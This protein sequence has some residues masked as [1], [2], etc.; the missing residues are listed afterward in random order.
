MTSTTTVY[1]VVHREF[2]ACD[3]EGCVFTSREEARRAI[4]L[5][6]DYYNRAREIYAIEELN[7]CQ[8]VQDFY[9]FHTLQYELDQRNSQIF[10]ALSKKYG[11]SIID[12]IVELSLRRECGL[13]FVI[14]YKF[15]DAIS[16]A[17]SM[18]IVKEWIKEIQTDESPFLLEQPYAEKK[19]SLKHYKIDVNLAS[20]S[21]DICL[22]IR[23]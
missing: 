19:R 21:R 13:N 5:L 9:L 15:P 11:E 22:N 23:W 17:K 18:E 8:R 7:V 6:C 14:D 16:A 4:N 10:A 20:N 12:G 3:F 1:L 2:E